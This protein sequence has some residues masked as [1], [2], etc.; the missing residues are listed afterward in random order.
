MVMLRQRLPAARMTHASTQRLFFALRPEPPTREALVARA[1]HLE[2]TYRARWVR[3]ARYHVTLQFL[4]AREHF[5]SGFIRLAIRAAGDVH[6]A[7]FRWYPDCISGFPAKRP[8]CIACA[9]EAGAPLHVLH[10]ALGKALGD[11]GI[12]MHDER[13]WRP[14]VTLGYGCGDVVADTTIPAVDFP[15][16]AFFLLHS[17]PGEKNYREVGCWSLSGA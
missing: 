13:P 14:H 5:S 2:P 7:A 3:P 6:A 17:V 16:R 1:R 8:P 4:G 10:Q 9:R 15:V 11:H 12:A